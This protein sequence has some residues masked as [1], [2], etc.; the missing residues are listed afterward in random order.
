MKSTRWC[1]PKQQVNEVSTGKL[2]DFITSSNQVRIKR[3]VQYAANLKYPP[4]TRKELDNIIKENSDIFSKDQYNV[5]I[6]THPPIKIPTEGPPCISASY[7]IP[8]KFRPWADN[9]IN[10]LLE[11]GMIQHTMS[12]WASSIIIVP[13][14]GLQSDLENPGKPFLVT[15][16]LCL[17]C[18]YHKLNLKLP[19]DLW[20]YNKEGRRIVKQGINA[21]YPLPQ[22]DEMFDTICR[23]CLTTL[24]CTGAFH[25][26]RLSPDAAKKS[27]F[28]THLGKFE[29]RVVPFSLALLPSYYSKVMQD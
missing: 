7:T 17:C 24:D 2:D 20:N 9:I 29:W 28:T 3:P 12:T 10:K 5:G 27:A 23:K 22:I 16:K 25:G 19:V 21:P 15:A 11:A 18:D 1:N 14:K 8:L 6:S 13:K 26:L 4:K